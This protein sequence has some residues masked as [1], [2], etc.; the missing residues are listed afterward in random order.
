MRKR[1]QAGGRAGSGSG[2]RCTAAP[3]SVAKWKVPLCLCAP[4]HLT[5]W[6]P[7]STQRAAHPAAS[8]TTTQRSPLYAR[9]PPLALTPVFS[10]QPTL[11]CCSE[12]A[13]PSPAPPRTT[14]P[15]THLAPADAG[16]PPPPR[17]WRLARPPCG[18]PAP[19]AA[20]PPPPPAAS[21]VSRAA[22]GGRGGAGQGAAAAGGW[23]SWQAAA[24][25]EAPWPGRLPSKGGP[26]GAPARRV[27]TQLAPCASR[28]AALCIGA[29][30]RHEAKGQE[31]KRERLW[32]A[33]CICYSEGAAPRTHHVLAA[34]ALRVDPLHRVLAL[35]Q[36]RLVLAALGHQRVVLLL[37]R[38][39]L[40]LCA[41]RAGGRAGAAMAAA[42]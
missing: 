11:P 26:R 3:R 24:S 32:L 25:F 38:R 35:P 7:A 28:F 30:A 13:A 21:A 33:T 40:L 36:R 18:Q 20:W 34:P 1:G 42:Q 6:Q 15:R 2:R 27:A 22:R 19:R 12:Q 16:S 37:R 8:S 14:H 39:P 10:K 9:G 4:H 31:K 23:G 17:A 29:P 41:G 5:G